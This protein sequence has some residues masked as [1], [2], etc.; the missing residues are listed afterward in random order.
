MTPAPENQTAAA[1]RASQ[2]IQEARSAVALSGAGISTPSGIPDFRTAGSG[3]WTRFN[4][5]EVASLS[6]FR[7]HP[8]R[9]YE[10]L[11]PLASHMLNAQPNPGHLALAELESSGF[12]Q[13]VIT[14]NIDTLH[15]R[16][17]SKNVLEVHGTFESLTCTTCFNQ[18][19]TGEK[20]L[21]TFIE[22]EDIPRC[23]Q[24]GGI[25]KP[26]V[27]L[28]GE[29][30]PAQIWQQARTL[31]RE[32]DVMLVLGSSLTVAP[33]SDLPESALQS[34][35]KLIIINQMETHLDQAAQVVIH[36]D[37][38]EVLPEIKERINHGQEKNQGL[39]A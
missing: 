9:F 22:G 12:I 21:K 3:L 19:K 1:S 16:A 18:Q 35:A 27:V 23:S 33:V 29:Q 6:A 38:E 24:C 25:L 7:Y 28:F 31:S 36:G 11:R 39:T 34:G 26:D 8:R 13:A 30:L 2:L 14:Q 37:L 17:G 32:C 20:I 15:Q 10:W 4:P 5:L